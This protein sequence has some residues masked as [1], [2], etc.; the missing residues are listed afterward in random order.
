MLYDIIAM[1]AWKYLQVS[2]KNKTETKGANEE[3]LETLLT[4]TICRLL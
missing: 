1:A 2:Q 3:K 4:K